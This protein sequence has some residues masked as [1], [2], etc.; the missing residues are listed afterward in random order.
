MPTRPG[1]LGFRISPIDSTGL[2]WPMLA[3]TWT[4]AGES[5][6]FDA[7]WISDHLTD[8]S[9]ERGGAA[10]E[11]LTTLAALTSRV[12]GL[13]VGVA[14]ASNTFRHP[15]VLAKSAV[16]LDNVTGGRFILGLGAGWHV[17]EH[18]QFGV[19]LPPI[20]ERFAR[21]ES[22]VEALASLFSDA[23]RRPPGVTF[24]DPYYP[25]HGAT[26]EPGSI[27]KGGPAL[28][29]GVGK[30]RGIALAARFA[31]GWPMPGNRPGDVAYFA[32]KRDEI[33]AAIEAAGRDPDKFTF[34]AQLTCGETEVELRET[35]R[36]ARA[37]MRAGA[38][39]V[40][41]SVPARLGPNG[42]ARAASEV[43][44]PLRDDVG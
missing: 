32:E 10:M 43:A 3:A 29:L 24:E 28:W 30:P 27:R 41:L 40:I 22:A 11:S 12:P 37:L 2:D 1:P 20:G 15:A 23:A 39:H 9:K 35:L 13:W 18:D 17:G 21:F 6:L 4:L 25:L 26:M 34:A 5:D 38:N 44:A 19:S 36:V 8:A 14:V 42:M 33:R 7:G 16:V 31:D